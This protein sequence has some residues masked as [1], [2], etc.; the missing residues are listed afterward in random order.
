[1]KAIL[2][3]A[4]E[5]DFMEKVEVNTIKDCLDI[6]HSVVIDRARDCDKDEGFEDC[7]IVVTIYDDYIE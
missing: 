1:M 3:K 7:E 4:S 2:K 6:Y 5:W